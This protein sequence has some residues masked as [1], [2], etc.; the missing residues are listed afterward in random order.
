MVKMKRT[1]IAAVTLVA[2]LALT[3]CKKEAAKDEWSTGKY[4]PPTEPGG[5]K[6][7]KP[8]PRFSCR[9]IGALEKWRFN[10]VASLLPDGRVLVAGGRARKAWLMSTEILD[11]NSGKSERAGAIKQER[12]LHT[13][14]KLVD[15]RVLVVGGGS[16]SLEIYEPKRKAW[17]VVGSLKADAVSVAAVQL[18]DGRVYIA[19]GELTDRRAL[20][21][22]AFFW[23]PKT[24]KLSPSTALKQGFKG[25]A[26]VA[27]DGRIVVLAKLTGAD[28]S[29]LFVVDPDKGTLTP[30]KPETL[31][32]K[33]LGELGRSKGGEEVVLAYG[34][35]GRPITP[36]TGLRGNALLR[37]F[38][39]RLSWRKLARL[40]FDHGD[41]GAAVALS[42]DKILVLGG[43]N[44]K[45]AAIEVCTPESI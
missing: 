24:G 42:A 29:K 34:P 41:G 25:S 22:D 7:L 33:A 2:A 27:D 18:K 35:D 17:G 28:R 44:E 13:T 38:P 39:S 12:A 16:K 37:F 30:H 8:L 26:Y 11:P 19:G 45:D 23:D 3:G 43:S 5:P 10:P 20:S 15:G 21:K 32:L 40:T 31:M 14:V 36:P 1:V 9:V 6:K 4:V